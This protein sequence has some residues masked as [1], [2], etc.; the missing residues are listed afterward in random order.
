MRFCNL[1]MGMVQAEYKDNII[2]KG[3][4]DYLGGDEHG[5]DLKMVWHEL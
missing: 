2:R 4:S 1:S 5:N 3:D